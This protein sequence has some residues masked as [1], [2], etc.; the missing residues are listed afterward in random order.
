MRVAQL[1]W[2]MMREAGGQMESTWHREMSI[3]S[4]EHIRQ[5]GKNNAH[6]NFS[7]WNPIKMVDQIHGYVSYTRS[8]S[9]EVIGSRRF[10][11]RWRWTEG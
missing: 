9:Y 3:F 5:W 11:G 8:V 1:S 2:D 4:K 6:I 10:F 7:W